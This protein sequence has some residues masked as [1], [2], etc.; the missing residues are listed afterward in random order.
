MA[1]AGVST[2]EVDPDKDVSY[3]NMTLLDASKTIETTV[4]EK[5][6]ENNDKIRFPM[7]RRFLAKDSIQSS[8]ASSVSKKVT[9]SM[10]AKGL[11]KQMPKLLMYIM[12]KKIGMTLA[13]KT[14]FLE[15]AYIVIEFQ[16]KHVD[17]QMLLAKIQEGMPDP[18]DIDDKEME[19]PAEVLDAWMKEME[20]QELPSESEAPPPEDTTTNSNNSNS[21]GWS[22]SAWIAAQSEYAITQLLPEGYKKGLEHETMPSFVQKKITEEMGAMMA[23]KMEKKLLEAEIAVLPAETQARYFYS[24]LESLR[25]TKS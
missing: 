20:G 19:V 14:V 3:I 7:V 1:T 24:N 8:I 11:S 16:I 18:D 2:L 13:A 10:V 25:E 23:K 9:P 15:D 21:Q 5:L 22:W 12:H 6:K 17:T 4:K